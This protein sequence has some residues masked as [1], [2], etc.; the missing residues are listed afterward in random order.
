MNL[1]E[2]IAVARGDKPAD[3]LFTNARIINTFNGEIETGNVAIYRDTIAGIGDYSKAEEFI[4][5]KGSYLAP[6]LINGHS[7]IES[8]MLH[9]AQYAEAVVTR[10]TSTVITDL[11]EITN[12][13]GFDGI[14]FVIRCSQNLPMDMFFMVPSCVPATNMETSGAEL[15]AG[16]IKKALTEQEQ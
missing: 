7:H 3:L 10:G 6:G 16:D 9:P 4:D 2:L 14:E 8:S 12:V 5:L 11:H 13:C 15:T 1:D